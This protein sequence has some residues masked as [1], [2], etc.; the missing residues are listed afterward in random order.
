MNDDARAAAAPKDPELEWLETVYKPGATQ[1]TVRA[2]ISGMLIG[3]LMCISNLYVVLKTGWSLGVTVT[4]CI[5]AFGVFK[6][7]SKIGLTK[8]PFGLLENN[9]MSSVASAAGYMTG[10]GNMAAIPALFFLTGELP[11]TWALILWF[12]VIAALGVFAAIPIKRQLIN[13]DKLPFPSGIATAETLRTLHELDHSSADADPK[14]KEK[15]AGTASSALYL[16]VA[17]IFAALFAFFRDAKSRFIPFNLPKAIEL[18]VSWAGFKASDWSLGIDGSL[19]LVGAGGIIGIRTC[20]TM[21]VS[22]IVLYVFVAPEL[23]ANELIPTA[24]YKEI[25]KVSLWPAAALMLSNGLVSFG[26]QWRSLLKSFAGLGKLLGKKAEKRDPL[27]DVECPGWWFPTGFLVLGP[28]VVVLAMWLFGFPWWAGAMALPLAV[29]MGVVAAR[30]TGETDITPTK[31]LGPATQLIFGA[32]VPG[33]LKANIMGA[34]ITGGVGL[35]AADL[36][37]DLKSGYLLGANPRQQFL[38][39][40][41]GCVAGAAI[42]VPAFLLLVPEKEILGSTEFPAPSVMVWAGVSKAL[43]AGLE[44]VPASVRIATLIAAGVGTLLAI[45]E[46]FTPAK[47]KK[48]IPS[49]NGIGIALVIPGANSIAMFT[50]ALIVQIFSWIRPKTAAA[51]STPIASGLIAGES[52]MG[53]AVKGLIVA[54]VFEKT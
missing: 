9:A 36:L 8:K 52:L 31:A 54:G 15:G 5:I 30:V 2:V 3:A 10:G 45:I 28:I 6:L 34:N 32:S 49:A 44:S 18:P 21:M 20:A 48:F 53:V 40:L 19:V 23:L 51:A 27:A 43:V 38:A 41:F 42:V 37:T 22:A 39:Q 7:I 35:H 4:A 17:A 50:G 12:A 46:R 1:L 11:T 26:F 24:S 29:L 47:A 14:A 25:V 33:N 13:I 16:G